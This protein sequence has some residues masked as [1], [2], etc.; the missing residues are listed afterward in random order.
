VGFFWSEKSERSIK[1]KAKE[2]QNVNVVVEAKRK[3]KG[4]FDIKLNH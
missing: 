3:R 1:E 4:V 2:K